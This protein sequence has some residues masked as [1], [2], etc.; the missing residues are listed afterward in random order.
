MAVRDQLAPAKCP[1]SRS[2]QMLPS[3]LV[4][5]I[6]VNLE[7]ILVGVRSSIVPGVAF[8]PPPDPPP[9]WW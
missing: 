8:A 9:G 1:Y 2:L 3:K 6:Y 7:T 5:R 4:F